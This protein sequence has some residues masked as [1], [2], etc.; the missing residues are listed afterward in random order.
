MHDAAQFKNNRQPKRSAYVAVWHLNA[1]WS[2]TVSS[3][4]GGEMQPGVFTVAKRWIFRTGGPSVL[5]PTHCNGTL[6]LCP[7]VDLFRV[8]SAVRECSRNNPGNNSTKALLF[9]SKALPFASR[10]IEFKEESELSTEI[11][12]QE[13]PSRSAVRP[14]LC[15]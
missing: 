11:I 2:L 3:I 5:S 13:Q 7:S 10:E 12:D 9:R 14:L 1:E 4:D 8:Q 15:I 6:E